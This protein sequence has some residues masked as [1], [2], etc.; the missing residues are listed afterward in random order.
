MAGG[1]N[2]ISHEGREV[3][4]SSLRP[5][6]MMSV[7]PAVAPAAIT[8]PQSLFSTKRLLQAAA[9]YAWFIGSL[10]LAA[11]RL[12]WVRGWIAV[13]LWVVG[14]TAIG[15]IGQRYNAQMMAERSK[16]RRKDTK[17]FDKIFLAAFMP[18]FSI[19]PAV[20]GLDA[21]RYHWSS[22][23]FAFVYVGII[24]FTL[25]MV[26]IASVLAVNPYAES[27]VRIQTDRGQTVI[28]SG[29]YRLVRHPMYAGSFL[30]N[31]GMPLIWGSVWAL[32]LTGVIALLF[33]WRTAREDQTLR[34]ELPGYEEYAARTRYRL[35]PGLW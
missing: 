10:F 3:A 11:G 26:L 7:P 30:M 2:L 20:A 14:L 27:S 24:L 5:G 31:L 34:R 19:Q 8:S 18:L 33:I 35:L 1:L 16:W 4:R 9:T 23:P 6:G 15:L 13:A 12:D 25:A 29:P 21:V 22:M 32:V 28:T 17:P